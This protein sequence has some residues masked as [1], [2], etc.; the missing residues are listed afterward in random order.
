MGCAPLAARAQTP[1]PVT[2]AAVALEVAEW[3]TMARTTRVR[4]RAPKLPTGLV[5]PAERSEATRSRAA[6]TRGFLR[7]QLEF[8]RVRRAHESKAD[9]VNGLFAEVGIKA[10]EVFFRVFKRERVLEVWGR[11]QASG[12]Y[13]LLQSYPIC[14]VS[15]RLGPKR[16]EGDQQI[17]EGF[18]SIDTLNPWSDYHL[19]MHVNYPNSVDQI[20]GDGGRL[21]GDIYIHGGCATIGCVPV[22]DRL[23]EEIYLIAVQ[24]R[25]AGQRKIPVH[26]F[27]TRL[28]DSG[29]AWLERT[30]GRGFV[31][32]PFWQ[33]LQEGY[34]AFER[35][36]I[37]PA[38]GHNE[39][40][41]TFMPATRPNVAG[42]AASP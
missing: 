37:V 8:P 11:E 14:T 22:T 19:S 5:R 1:A 24:A 4:P 29:M 18:Y 38:V 40:T 32:F 33:N 23:I 10:P 9:R 31:D 35:S 12:E 20:R 41:Y 6:A 21:G 15:G 7:R 3:V 27:P 16:R 13:E 28:D 25:D 2:R 34:L 17:P 39:G 26:I 30:Y 36:H 42:V